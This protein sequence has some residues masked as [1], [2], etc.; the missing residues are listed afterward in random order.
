MI[1][2]ID[3][4]KIRQEKDYNWTNDRFEKYREYLQPIH[5]LEDLQSRS[6]QVFQ[7]GNILLY[8]ESFID[9]TDIRNEALYRRKRLGEFS[10]NKN[11]YLVLFTGSGNIRRLNENIANVPVSVLYRN[12]ELFVKKYSDGEVDLKCLLFGSNPE[13]EEKLS[14]KINS[15]LIEIDNTT[16]GK[17]GSNNL[18][19]RTD[20]KYIHNPFEGSEQEIIFDVTDLEFTKI[21]NSKLNNVHY[22]NIFIPLCC[23]PTLSDYNGLRLATHIRC[24]KTINQTSRIF[25][26]GVVGLESL[27]EHEY[28]NILRTK[29]VFLIPFSKRA[30][31]DAISKE[32]SGYAEEEL[33]VEMSKLNLLVPS[34]YEDNHSI[35]NEWS[36]YRWAY[37]I[38][39]Y[40]EGIG[41]INTS[42][43]N[44]LYFKYL[45]TVYPVSKINRIN[46]EKLRLQL[47]Q[48][49]KVLYID[50]EAGKGWYEVLCKIIFDINKLDFSC[51]D[52]DFKNMAQDE[53]IA[54]ALE[55]VKSFDADVVILDFRLHNSDF[56]KNVFDEI[57]GVRI[58]K[59]I[60]RSINR[61]I[62]VILFS[63][64]SKLWNLQQLQHAGID[65]FILK[66]SP[67]DSKDP[68][69]TEEAID[70]FMKAIRRSCDR[71]YLKAIYTSNKNIK[72]KISKK[73]I[74]IDIDNTKYSDLQVENHALLVAEIDSIYEILN[75]YN[76]NKFNHAMIMQFKIMEILNNIYIVKKE[77][78]EKM[79]FYDNEIV[80]YYN[81]EDNK[82]YEWNDQILSWDNKLKKMV[83][84]KISSESYNSTRN[85]IDCLIE[86]RT[87]IESKKAIHLEVKKLTEYRNRYIH[88][89][90]NRKLE[91]LNSSIIVNWMSLVENV[92]NVL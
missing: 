74:D 49:P 60:K 81:Y 19:I 67:N 40:D 27:L 17:K 62:Q 90:K 25:I 79:Y 9:K 69:C 7:E 32:N 16:F 76:L 21:I 58:L 1:Y 10:Q 64:T 11:S 82:L 77:G 35:A 20:E 38:N 66:E 13:V 53:I 30:I 52:I 33:P 70:R 34:N 55:R 80:K 56:T 29:N 31:V 24:T 92:I 78:D 63:A 36:I 42:V 73:Q 88:A 89:N 51:L 71:M 61:G 2:L 43:N 15:E 48:K 47:V 22:D 54:H 37:V 83:K 8:H 5:T 59:E 91:P 44:N 39:A 46:E 41:R 72:E 26:Y 6:D 14:I 28:F 84:K 86:Q 68:Q 12:L 3:D 65:E 23:G 50:D 18:Y 57:T 85:K 87:N 4:K 45:Q 75:T